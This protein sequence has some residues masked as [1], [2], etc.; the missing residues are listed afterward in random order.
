VNHL[1]DLEEVNFLDLQSF[2]LLDLIKK[3]HVAKVVHHSEQNQEAT[4]HLKRG[5]IL[6]LGE[7]ER[8]VPRNSKRKKEVP[9]QEG[10]GFQG[11]KISRSHVL[12]ETNQEVRANLRSAENPLQDPSATTKHQDHSHAKETM[13]EIQL[14]T[15]NFLKEK[16]DFLPI[17]KR[18]FLNLSK[19]EKKELIGF[20]NSKKKMGSLS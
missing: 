2:H 12:I 13:I 8:E 11:R 6:D 1:S 10:T 19:K 3:S 15:K 17:A 9:H 20:R 16:A 18:N 7:M 4:D 14:L 5:Q